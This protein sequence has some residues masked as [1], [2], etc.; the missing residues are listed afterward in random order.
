MLNGQ[1]IDKLH[2]WFLVAI[3]P[4]IDITIYM[5]VSLKPGPAIKNSDGTKRVGLG[6]T[7]NL[8]PVGYA[9]IRVKIMS[10]SRL[11]IPSTDATSPMLKIRY[12]STLWCIVILNG[13]VTEAIKSIIT[14]FRLNYL[15]YYGRSVTR[16]LVN[17]PTCVNEQCM[18][19]CRKFVK[20]TRS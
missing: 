6:E 5:D 3:R 8:P 7:S 16:T 18:P 19:K 10:R 2:Y 15:I 14:G 1:V 12:C 4:L 11:S 13:K 17:I 9:Y 20:K